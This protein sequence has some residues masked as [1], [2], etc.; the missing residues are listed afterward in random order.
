MAKEEL[1]TQI[2]AVTHKQSEQM[3]TVDRDEYAEKLFLYI[4]VGV[5]G[6]IHVKIY[7]NSSASKKVAISRILQ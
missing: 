6:L 7:R 3:Y 1:S 5:C 2:E 4:S